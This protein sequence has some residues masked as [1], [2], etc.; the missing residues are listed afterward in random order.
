[1]TIFAQLFAGARENR[2][3]GGDSLVYIKISQTTLFPS[4]L[5]WMTYQS[6]SLRDQQDL[7]YELPQAD[8]GEKNY[9]ER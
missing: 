5:S 2:R 7:G 6:F 3:Q 4:L 9:Q 8:I 1:M